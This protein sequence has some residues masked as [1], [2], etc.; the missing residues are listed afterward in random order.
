[1]DRTRNLD[2]KLTAR[3]PSRPEM[4]PLPI[5]HDNAREGGHEVVKMIQDLL[6]RG[7]SAIVIR[8]V[9]PDAA[10][11]GRIL[12]DLFDGPIPSLWEFS[13]A[14]RAWNKRTRETREWETR[15]REESA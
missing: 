9:G 14:T 8:A 4:V 12:R 6:T 2:A 11:A 7:E 5:L 3:D 1:M 10:K 13:R 15:E